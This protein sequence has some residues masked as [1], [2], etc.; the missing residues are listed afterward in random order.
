MLAGYAIT[1]SNFLLPSKWYETLQWVDENKPLQT[2]WN[3]FS[4]IYTY[5]KCMIYRYSVVDQ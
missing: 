1:S 5:S 4:T 3:V 2:F